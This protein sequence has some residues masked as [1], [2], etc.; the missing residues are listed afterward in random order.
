MNEAVVVEMMRVLNEVNEKLDAGKLALEEHMRV[1]EHDL[2]LLHDKIGALH[3]AF[4]NGDLAGHVAYHMDI[5][6]I[7]AD[8]K[9]FWKKMRYE[10]SK[11]GLIGLVGWLVVLLW[12]GVLHGPV[13]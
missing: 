12:N 1:E 2:Q 3:M 11:Y 7:M 10:V 9:E 8:R 5:I 13:K 4:P 6:Q